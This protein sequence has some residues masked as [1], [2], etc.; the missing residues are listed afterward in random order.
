MIVSTL[1]RSSQSNTL[2]FSQEQGFMSKVSNSPVKSLYKLKELVPGQKLRVII[3]PMTLEESRQQFPYRPFAKNSE[4]IYLTNEKNLPEWLLI[5][6]GKAIR[7]GTCYAA[8]DIKYL[9]ETS[10]SL[11]CPDC[12]G[13]SEL[14]GLDPRSSRRKHKS[15]F[16][17][18]SQTEI[19]FPRI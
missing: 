5:L 9:K 11:L 18:I 2:K 1:V 8:T 19:F 6:N 3:D 10:K 12:D 7:C 4:S 14:Y 17:K 13:R 15:S 16:K